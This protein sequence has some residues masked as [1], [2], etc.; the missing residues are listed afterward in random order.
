MI[1]HRRIS[2][3][4]PVEV[5]DG[6]DHGK[7]IEGE[8]G[9]PP[10][11][12]RMIPISTQTDDDPDTTFVLDTSIDE[13]DKPPQEYPHHEGQGN[14]HAPRFRYKEKDYSQVV[15]LVLRERK[16]MKLYRNF[17]I[18]LTTSFAGL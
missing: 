3:V 13:S 5:K 6:W 9:I 18:T 10:T 15:R 1:L 14:A 16:D 2:E 7:P 17:L 11:T 12:L 8:G 4:D